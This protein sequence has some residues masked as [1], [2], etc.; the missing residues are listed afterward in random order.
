MLTERQY[1]IVEFMKKNK[2]ASVRRLSKEFFVSEMTVRRDLTELERQGYLAR[3][4]GGAYYCENDDILPVEARKKL[5]S[6]EKQK[7]SVMAKKY[8]SDSITVYIDSS[9]TCMYIIPILSEYNDIKIVTNSIQSLM[10]AAK[11]HIPCII[12]GGEYYEHDMCTVGSVTE[13]FLENLN[14]D[15]AFFS[16]KGISDDGIISDDDLRQTAVRKTVMKN[17]KKV[18]F[19][20]DST[21]THKKYL[22][23]VCKSDAIDGVIML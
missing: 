14:V 5:H 18:I 9:S 16:S 8:L 3:Y 6:A 11:Y 23:T 20:F 4:N 12:A 22:Y 7:L 17:V 2:S 19:M 21:K 13:N 15:A 1:K 10:T